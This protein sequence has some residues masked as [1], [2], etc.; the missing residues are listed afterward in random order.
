MYLGISAGL[1]E[2]KQLS[3][4]VFRHT[5]LRKAFP[6]EHKSAGFG[7]S[8]LDSQCCSFAFLL[9]LVS[10]EKL[11][12]ESSFVPGERSPSLLLSGKHSQK[13]K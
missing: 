13:N 1:Q 2:G 4:L 7:V 5:C 11:E 9:R 3:V 6:A 8:K 10:A 12:R